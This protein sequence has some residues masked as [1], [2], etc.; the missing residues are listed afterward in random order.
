VDEMSE[1]SIAWQFCSR[2]Q[3]HHGKK[4]ASCT[5]REP[6]EERQVVETPRAAK[7]GLARKEAGNSRTPPAPLSQPLK[8]T[9][10]Y[11]IS[12]NCAKSRIYSTREAVVEY[13]A[14]R[15]K[16][17][18]VH[19]SCAHGETTEP[20]HWYRRGEMDVYLDSIRAAHE[21]DLTSLAKMVNWERKQKKAAGRER[22]E[23]HA[24]NSALVEEMQ[25]QAD[26]VAAAE[27][28]LAEWKQASGRFEDWGNDGVEAVTKCDKRVKELE[29]KLAELQ[30]PNRFSEAHGGIA[31]HLA[32]AV[33]NDY[34][35]IEPLQELMQDITSD[36]DYLFYPSDRWKIGFR[37]EQHITEWKH[38]LEKKVGK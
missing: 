13:K 3:T 26:V 36:L 27:K 30:E 8:P 25:K 22:D 35:E 6:T 19:D 5:I 33:L 12:N 14:N 28:K 15:A 2:H 10:E 18:P 34:A 9:N 38:R 1:H 32:K 31:F 11:R 7:A 29:K 16:P 4:Y 20:G 17:L 24:K 37:H 23:I 21:K